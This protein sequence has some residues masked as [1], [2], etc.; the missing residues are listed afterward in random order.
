MAKLYVVNYTEDMVGYFLDGVKTS[1]A[2]A[3]A[4]REELIKQGK[5]VILS[6]VEENSEG[7]KKCLNTTQVTSSKKVTMGLD[8]TKG[9]INKQNKSGLV[10]L[11]GNTVEYVGYDTDPRRVIIRRN[12]KTESIDSV[13]FFE[14]AVFQES[15]RLKSNA[16][17]M[18]R[19]LSGKS[20]GGY[21]LIDCIFIK[22]IGAFLF[23]ASSRELAEKGEFQTTIY[24]GVKGDFVVSLRISLASFKSSEEHY[25][26][27]LAIK[28]LES[29][30][31]LD[32]F[33]IS[34]NKGH[35]PKSAVDR[36]AYYFKETGQ[37]R[38]EDYMKIVTLYR[39]GEGYLT[40]GLYS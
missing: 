15:V 10:K 32:R 2:A 24:V 30:P 31:T 26:V 14:N 13:L 4:R 20:K 16:T 36:W 28:K 34:L 35:S 8:S 38:E 6:T 5:H 37:I 19:S 39:Q 22:K 12:G 11:W 27:D 3:I 40:K 1:K 7:C 33:I 17:I 21:M 29:I 23:Y 25:L 18:R 9:N